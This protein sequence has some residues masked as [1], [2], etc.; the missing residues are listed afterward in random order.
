MQSKFSIHAL[1]RPPVRRYQRSTPLSKYCTWR[2]S[3]RDIGMTSFSMVVSCG[4]CYPGGGPLEYDRHNRRYDKAAG[5]LNSGI[6]SGGENSFDGDYFKAKW[7]KTGVIEADC[8]ICHLPAYNNQK[9]KAQ[10]TSLNFRWAATAG[11][12]F[13]KIEGKLVNG[14]TPNVIYDPGL[15]MEDG[16]VT[17]KIVRDTPTKNCELCG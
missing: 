15:F 10:I 3:A 7:A 17:L 16:K 9:R 2:V 12:G 11:A 1:H 8:L 14:E 13:G 4:K 5:D 6:R